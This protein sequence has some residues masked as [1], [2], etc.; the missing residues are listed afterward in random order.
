MG[1]VLGE[2]CQMPYPSETLG[3]CMLQ[4]FSLFAL[5]HRYINAWSTHYLMLLIL[6]V[7][8]VEAFSEAVKATSRNQLVSSYCPS[9]PSETHSVT[10]DHNQLLT[11]NLPSLLNGMYKISL[12]F[13]FLMWCPMI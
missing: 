6:R 4:L 1:W 13:A 12:K 3:M 5:K 9:P 11:A 10:R 7:V 8:A 2:G